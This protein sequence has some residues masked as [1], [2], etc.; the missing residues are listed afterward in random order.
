MDDFFDASAMYFFNSQVFAQGESLV[1]FL[2]HYVETLIIKQTGY[3]D[4]QAADICAKALLKAWQDKVQEV[5]S[6][7]VQDVDKNLFLVGQINKKRSDVFV[8]MLLGK[9]ALVGKNPISFP[10]YKS[11][12]TIDSGICLALDRPDYRLE[13]VPFDSVEFF[14]ESLPN[15]E[16]GL[17]ASRI[18]KI[19]PRISI[20]KSTLIKLKRKMLNGL[21]QDKDVYFIP[22]AENLQDGKL[23]TFRVPEWFTSNAYAEPIFCFTIK[24]NK[25]KKVLQNQFRGPIHELLDLLESQYGI[26]KSSRGVTK[27]IWDASYRVAA[28]QNMHAIQLSKKLLVE[29]TPANKYDIEGEYFPL[30]E[31]IYAKADMERAVNFVGSLTKDNLTSAMAKE[32]SLKLCFGEEIKEMRSYSSLNNYTNM[33]S[34]FLLQ[35]G[36]H[37]DTQE[38]FRKIFSLYSHDMEYKEKIYTTWKISNRAPFSERGKL[39]VKI[40]PKGNVESVFQEL[41]SM[42]LCAFSTSAEFGPH[43]PVHAD[44]KIPNQKPPKLQMPFG[45]VVMHGLTGIR[46]PQ[47]ALQRFDQ[48]LEYGGLLSYSERRRH[49]IKRHTMSPLGDLASG[50]DWGVPCTI[51]RY[52]SYGGGILFV[53]KPSVLER[54]HIFFADRDYGGG[55]NRFVNYNQYAKTLGQ[56][57]FWNSPSH[58]M[59]Q[60][61]INKIA[62]AKQ[63]D[64]NQ[65]L[66]NE[67]W[68]RW[69]IAWDEI[70]YV[71]VS[72]EDNLYNQVHEK[73]VKAKQK[74]LVPHSVKIKM[75]VG[76]HI[77]PDQE[78]FQST[79]SLNEI[80]AYIFKQ[81]HS[82]FIA[83][84][85]YMN[86]SYVDENSI[87]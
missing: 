51:S 27:N 80:I 47:D 22:Q 67:V 57:N 54:K 7:S 43:N 61:H 13:Y 33:V 50:I 10:K 39:L 82:Q 41:Q 9:K 35:S 1:D 63:T 21:F 75:F 76:G 36:L 44:Y 20:S 16:K 34:D 77:L 78:K 86:K 84:H 24:Q 29:I 69:R 17:T 3:S 26:Y 31:G 19:H 2:K 23:I 32:H 85:K 25:R 59:R 66:F 52:P 42:D 28:T 83:T 74:G 53:L 79:Q 45:H 68:F 64:P 37:K 30:F 15:I 55:K 46:N 11:W 72:S 62:M 6:Q 70:D 5:N 65:P 56:K 71:V 60:R 4:Q 58:K 18:D 14:S 38:L 87:F 40:K 73:L 8:K 81:Q 48:I 12:A 49:G